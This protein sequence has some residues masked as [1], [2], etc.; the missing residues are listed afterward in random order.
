MTRGDWDN[1]LLQ[2]NLLDVSAACAP[3]FET[4]T[5]GASSDQIKMAA[6]IAENVRAC[7]VDETL[8]DGSLEI[9]R[10]DV[11]EPFGQC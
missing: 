7:R 10:C 11:A 5:P 3:R 1:V 2:V 6:V 4:G 9:W 8:R